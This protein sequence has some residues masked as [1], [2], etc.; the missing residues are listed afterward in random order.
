MGTLHNLYLMKHTLV[1][2]CAPGDLEDLEQIV[3]RSTHDVDPP[4][5]LQTGL[6]LTGTLNNNEVT[7][8]STV[9]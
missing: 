1:L 6:V 2:V 8:C 4:R 5:P 9:V 3:T 7:K